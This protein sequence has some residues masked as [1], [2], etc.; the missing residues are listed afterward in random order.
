MVGCV[1][2]LEVLSRV[3][4]LI[5]RGTTLSKEIP[6]GTCKGSLRSRRRAGLGQGGLLIACLAGLGWK[7]VGANV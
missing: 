7:I 4:H 3:S 5:R 6:R 2:L 1:G